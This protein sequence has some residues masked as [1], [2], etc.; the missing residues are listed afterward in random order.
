ME[1]AVREEIAAGVEA[2][3]FGDIF[4]QDLRDYRE[5]NLARAGLQAIFP[6][7]KRDTHEL[8]REF[9][10]LRF[11]AITVCIDPAK[12]DRRFAGRKLTPQFFADLPADVDPCGE[13][14]EFHTFVFDGP[15]FRNPI[16]VE[17]VE[18]VER[19]GFIFCD[20]NAC[21]RPTFFDAK[22]KAPCP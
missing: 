15:I 17:R 18:V 14:G 12:L 2:V 16:A 10:A 19:D 3:A 4:L 9:C 21:S 5:R 1:E 6:L 22:E 20:L 8:A 13:N 7:W 11:R